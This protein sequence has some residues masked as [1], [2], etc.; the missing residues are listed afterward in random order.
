M[1]IAIAVILLCA[2]GAEA[3]QMTYGPILGRGRMGSEMIVK[4]G[5]LASEATTV[6]WRE[7]GTSTFT[8][9]QG[10]N[11]RD[12]EVVLGGLAPG[13]AYEYF[14]E[15]GSAKSPTYAFTTCP[16]P[17]APMDIAFYGDSKSGIVAHARV[18][19]VGRSLCPIVVDLVDEKER[20]VAHAGMTYMRLGREE[21]PR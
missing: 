13:K 15:S 8:S 7:K 2:A 6:S 3:Q 4:W 20:M 17:G 11:A 18:L 10:T 5:T 19:K 1:R 16:V 21:S 12:H 9:T 14:V